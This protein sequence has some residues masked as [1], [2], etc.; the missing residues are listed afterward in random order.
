MSRSGKGG[1]RS[2][3]PRGVQEHAREAVRPRARALHSVHAHRICPHLRVRR[4]S[5]GFGCQ[6][7]S[8]GTDL[9]GGASGEPLAI[10]LRAGNAGSN[11]A[12]EHSELARLALAQL[13]RQARAAAS[14]RQICG[15]GDR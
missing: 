9:C 3:I 14:R 12:R 6:L 7:R 1:R 10:L 8:C 11:T 4:G 2:G 5:A 15:R 13:P